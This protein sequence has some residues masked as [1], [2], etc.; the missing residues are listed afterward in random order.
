VLAA[1]LAAYFALHERLPDLSIWWD[2]AVI[3][4]LV[5]P[6]VFAPVLLLLPLR[7]ARGLWLLALASAAL[8]IAFS[9]AEW[10]GAASF[11]KL[12]AATFFGWIFLD[13]FEALSWVV[14]V[15]LIIPW[16]DA[17]SVWRGPTNT[18]VHH[19][20]GVFERLSFAFPV[21]GE[22]A[23]ANLGIPDMLFFGLFLA[24]AERFRLRTRLTWILMTLSFGATIAISVWRDLGGL[25]A[26][27]LLSLAFL[28]ANAD[29]LW[30]R[31]RRPT[32]AET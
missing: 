12:A 9:A 4:L 27:P 5:M 30:A 7:R 20:A 26:L 6:A 1:A 18:I 2:V 10:Q 24:A 32:P 15:A 19:H 8:A 14:G 11:A 22:N 29:L 21:P 31:L 17:Y 3:A 16:V 23:T 28:S 25:P 13:L